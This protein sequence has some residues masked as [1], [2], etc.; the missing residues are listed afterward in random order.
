MVRF[1]AV[2]ETRV[3]EAISAFQETLLSFCETLLSNGSRN[4]SEWVVPDLDNSPRHNGKPG[5]CCVNLE[6][7]RFYDHN[8]EAEPQKGG[9]VD[10]W[11]ALFGVTDFV[12]IIS[13]WK[14]GSKTALCRTVLAV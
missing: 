10:L 12:E 13:A 4:G 2:G 11:T 1:H 6:T 5:S 8:P 3:D 7:G 14:L 9:P